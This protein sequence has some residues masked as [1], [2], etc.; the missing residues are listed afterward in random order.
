M[1]CCCWMLLENQIRSSLCV[2]HKKNATFLQEFGC[3]LQNIR[4]NVRLTIAHLDRDKT[5][6]CQTCMWNYV[7][8][9]KRGIENFQQMIW[10]F[11][12][13]KQII[14]HIRQ[15]AY[16]VCMCQLPSGDEMPNCELGAIP[17][18][19]DNTT[20]HHNFSVPLRIKQN[21]RPRR[22]W[23]RLAIVSLLSSVELNLSSVQWSLSQQRGA[24]NNGAIAL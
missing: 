8:V 12:G 21:N 13:S 19:T 17:H 10:T 3:T 15:H 24:N 18:N 4:P 20:T 5:M 9:L 23:H 1:H 22:D 7:K 2:I 11:L 6:I 14:R 16:G